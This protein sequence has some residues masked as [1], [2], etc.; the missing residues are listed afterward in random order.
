MKSLGNNRVFLLLQVFNKTKS[1]K[2]KTIL[3]IAVFSLLSFT[4]GQSLK[5]GI[6]KGVSR[7]IYTDEP[8]YAHSEIKIGNGKISSIRF[9]VRDSAKHEYFDD[10]YEKYFAGN[11]LYIRQC[12][13]DWKGIRSYPDSLM[14][15]HDL[16]KVDIIS[17]ATWSYNMFMDSVREAL[18]SAVEVE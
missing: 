12:R 7:S 11:D 10:E 13:N 1:M 4:T 2:T 9:F 3:I 5:D 18:S 6:Y 8:Y 16:S 17:G 14:K 15:Y